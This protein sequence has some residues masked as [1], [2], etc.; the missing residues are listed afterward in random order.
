[1]LNFAAFFMKSSLRILSTNICYINRPSPNL[2]S[3]SVIPC[4]NKDIHN[5]IQIALVVSPCLYLEEMIDQTDTIDK[6][7]NRYLWA[8][9]FSGWQEILCTK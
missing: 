9:L 2:T 6:V 5:T 4:K 8:E 7:T 1:M 3:L